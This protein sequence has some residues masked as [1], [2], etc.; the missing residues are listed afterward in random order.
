M[1]WWTGAKHRK[2]RHRDAASAD[3]ALELSLIAQ[4]VSEKQ[5]EALEELIPEVERKIN[6]IRRINRE[7]NFA[8]RLE[9]AYAGKAGE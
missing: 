2:F 7:N 6:V 1:M 3:K 8:A 5:Q 4:E 9:A